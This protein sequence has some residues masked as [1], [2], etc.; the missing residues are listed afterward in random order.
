MALQTLGVQA[1]KVVG[2]KVG[3]GTVVAQHVIEDDEHTMG[4]R[5]YGFLLAPATRQAMELRREVVVRGMGNGPGDLPEQ[6]AQPRIALGCGA[7][8][9]PAAALFVAGAEAGP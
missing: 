5:Y 3:V 8:E 9:P 6:G 4:D 7:A 1:L 2:T